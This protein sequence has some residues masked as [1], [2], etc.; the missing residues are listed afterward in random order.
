M[1]SSKIHQNQESEYVNSV[2]SKLLKLQRAKSIFDDNDNIIQLKNNNINNFSNKQNIYF[3][4]SIYDTNDTSPNLN[5]MATVDGSYLLSDDSIIGYNSEKVNFC[6]KNVKVPSTLINTKEYP[7]R[8]FSGCLP[9]EDMI[10]TNNQIPFILQHSETMKDTE[11]KIA[12]LQTTLNNMFIS[13]MKMISRNEDTLFIDKKNDNYNYHMNN[14]LE[15]KENQNQIDEYHELSIKGTDKKNFFQIDSSSVFDS[16]IYK[17][18]TEPLTSPVS[19]FE[20]FQVQ[21]NDFKKNLFCPDEI[22]SKAQKSID[23]YRLSKEK[24]C[25]ELNESDISGIAPFCKLKNEPSV[26]MSN[27]GNNHESMDSF[28]DEPTIKLIEEFSNDKESIDFLINILQNLVIIKKPSQR[29]FIM[30]FIKQLTNI[31]DNCKK[32]DAKKVIQQ[33]YN[34]VD[35]NEKTDCKLNIDD[36]IMEIFE[37]LSNDIFSKYNISTLNAS[38]KF[39]IHSLILKNFEKVFQGEQLQFFSK[40]LSTVL[41]NWIGFPLPMRKS[42]FLS[43]LDDLRVFFSKY[44]CSFDKNIYSLAQSPEYFDKKHSKK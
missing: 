12:F 10:I 35:M 31:V 33:K 30:S 37:V 19:D 20:D 34:H 25:L 15:E 17:E 11:E 39:L 4:D 14:G 3:D 42:H 7:N 36:V 44:S 13:N 32:N 43:F 23:K 6:D 38:E 9:V 24:R 40:E 29:A 22:S 26:E 18:D 16:I 28:C 21:T 2:L 1:K 27:D 5:E 41:D 8:T